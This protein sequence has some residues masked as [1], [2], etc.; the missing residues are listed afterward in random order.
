MADELFQM[1]TLSA[2]TRSRSRKKGAADLTETEFL[3]LDLLTRNKSMTVGDTAG[4]NELFD[5][6]EAILLD[7]VPIIPIYHYTRSFL[8]NPRIRGLQ[9]NLLAYYDYHKLY[10]DGETA[11]DS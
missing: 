7:N 3:T 1:Q 2:A 10:L 11:G 6:A 4:R 9:I 5:E 8:V